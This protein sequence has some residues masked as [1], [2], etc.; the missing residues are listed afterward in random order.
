MSEVSK[1]AAVA[2]GLVEN[3]NTS[4]SDLDVLSLWV[5][6]TSGGGATQLTKTILNSLISSAASAMTSVTGDVTGTGPGATAVTISNGVVTLAKMANLAANSIIG[7]NTVSSAT[8]IAL[9][10]TQVTAMLNV[11]SSSLQGLVPASGGGTVNFLRADGTFAAPAGTSYTFADSIV[12]TGGTVTLVNDSASP[13][14]SEYYGTDGSSVLGYH[15]LPVSGINQ[16]TGD[17]TAGPGTGSQ[18]ATLATVNGNV[19]SFGSSTAIPTITVNA[20]GLV[21]AVSTNVVIA[22]AGTLTGTVLASNVV[23]SSLTSLGAQSAAL[24]MNSNQ[25]NNLAAPTNPNDAVTKSYVDNFINATSWKTAVLVATTANITLSGEQTIDGELTS[26]SRVLVKNQTAPEDNGIYVSAAGA[27]SR[28]SDMNTWAEVPAAAVFV[29]SG[30]VGADLGWVCTSQPGGTLGTTAITFVQ[31]SSAGSYMA[32]GVTLQL[33]SGVFSIKNGGVGPSQLGAVT[34]GITTDQSGAGSTIEVKA[35]GISATQLATGAA[36]QLTIVGG[37]GTPLSVAYSPSTQLSATAN[38]ALTAQTSYV[39][40]GVLNGETTG[41]V[42]LADSTAA[43]T[44]LQFWGIGM[45]SGGAS[46]VSAG[47]AVRVITSGT[48]NL[49][50]SD[51][52]FLSTDL[53]LAVWLTTSG[54]FS[55]TAPSASGTASYK[56]GIV[57]ST[58]SIL[59]NAP[60]LTGIN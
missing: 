50:T 4:T 13:S 32:D 14:A 5:G 10:E 34:D 35:A 37:A 38:S 27:W 56:I 43:A 3:V 21:T 19:G 59:I 53:G 6:G 40:R 60:Q 24:N 39:V 55:T 20:K 18:A 46:G 36:D 30:T 9:T 23:T 49:G 28:A 47:G 57:T 52:P 29:Q 45:A 7:N 41:S 2:N 22:P 48:F 58:T 51:T 12:N 31:F 26:S 16:L 42:E 54:G 8:P 11:F 15:S 44:N 33:V 1:L 25:I 17:V